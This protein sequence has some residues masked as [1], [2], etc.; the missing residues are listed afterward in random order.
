MIGSAAGMNPCL[1]I[2]DGRMSIA[3]AGFLDRFGKFPART[4]MGKMLILLGHSAA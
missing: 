1:D 4:M 2:L 3:P